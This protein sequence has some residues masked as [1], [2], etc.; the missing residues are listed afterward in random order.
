MRVLV[1][2]GTGFVG[3][4]TV[5]ALIAR[6]HTPRVLA[7][8]P[9]DAPGA[10]GPLGCADVEAV[11]GDV[12]DVDSVRTALIGCDAV[13]H[14]GSVFSFDPRDQPR[15]RATNVAG[16]E[17]VLRAAADAGCDPI[18]HV[19]STLAFVPIAG[20]A[21]LT[22]DAAPGDSGF[23]YAQSKADSERVA[24]ALQAEGAPVVSV[25]PGWVWGPQDPRLGESC[26]VARDLLRGAMRLVPPGRSAIVDV[27]DLAELLASLVR[28]GRGPRRRLAAGTT[29]TFPELAAGLAEVTGRRVPVVV[30]PAAAAMCAGAVADGLR[31]I[32]PRLPANLEGIWVYVHGPDTDDG[33]TW[34][35]AGIIR[36]PLARTLADQV[37]WLVDHGVLTAAQAGGRFPPPGAQDVS[38][39]A[40]RRADNRALRITE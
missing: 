14:C 7:R 21:V 36:R 18:V 37:A 15:I 40:A 12:T 26:Q 9:E 31:R 19:S 17:L 6:G 35:D 34:S 5:A 10:L 28:P 11:R 39:F 3:A 4:H 24:R 25:A 2:G 20:G 30:V 27:R 1:T 23:P 32:G 33:D 13:V 16:T 22:A 8:R 29:V 38:G